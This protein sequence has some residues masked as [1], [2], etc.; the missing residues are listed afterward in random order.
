[1]IKFY[2]TLNGITRS[3]DGKVAQLQC[4]N[5]KNVFLQCI[6]KVRSDDNTVCGKSDNTDL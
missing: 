6:I 2:F 1:M 3:D 4:A 5:T